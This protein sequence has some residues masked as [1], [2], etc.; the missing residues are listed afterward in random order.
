MFDR[1]THWTRPKKKRKRKTTETVQFCLC[2][3]VHSTAY[4]SCNVLSR[5]IKYSVGFVFSAIVPLSK[6]SMQC[7]SPKPVV[8]V[9]FTLQFAFRRNSLLLFFS[10]AQFHYETYSLNDFNEKCEQN[11]GTN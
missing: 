8:T 2:A 3:R 4:E 7:T 11:M 1:I 6:H 9:N 10:S 5:T